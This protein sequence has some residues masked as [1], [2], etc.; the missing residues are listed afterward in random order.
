MERSQKCANFIHQYPKGCCRTIRYQ[1]NARTRSQG[2][3]NLLGRLAFEITKKRNESGDM[4]RLVGLVPASSYLSVTTSSDWVGTQMQ[5]H[6]S[7]MLTDSEYF[8]NNLMVLL[9]R[10]PVQRFDR[11]LLHCR[12][13][14]LS[15]DCPVPS[16]RN[17]TSQVKCFWKCETLIEV[18][19]EGSRQI[20]SFRD[21]RKIVKFSASRDFSVEID[22]FRYLRNV[23]NSR[24]NSQIRFL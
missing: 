8:A 15:N 20:T 10:Q 5:I 12:Q 1:I 16:H 6:K 23:Y 19:D 17:V 2:N 9:W 11:E 13:V 14:R 7:N 24:Y 18:Y 22:R 4:V 3:E 21:I